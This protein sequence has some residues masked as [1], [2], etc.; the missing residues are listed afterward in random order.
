[1]KT[2][3]PNLLFGCLWLFLFFFGGCK[4]ADDGGHVE[5][6]TRYEKIIGV[7][8]LTSLTQTDELAKTTG[9]K[10]TQLSLYNKFNF[11]DFK[12]TFEGDASNNPTKYTVS[13]A[14]PELFLKTGYWQMD[15]AFN[16]GKVAKILLYEDAQ[17]TKLTD[18]LEAITIPGSNNILEFKLI[19]SSEDVPF[20]SYQYSLKPVK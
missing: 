12:I 6:I 2:R 13:G 3:R 8:Q 16:T 17:K 10:T 5:P 18:Q 20:L 4:K 1:M 11:K 14:V 15:A 19:R 7:W 9:G